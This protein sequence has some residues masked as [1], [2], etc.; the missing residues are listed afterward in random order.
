[1]LFLSPNNVFLSCAVD[2]NLFEMNISYGLEINLLCQQL[3]AQMIVT[4]IFIIPSTDENFP[5]YSI[6]HVTLYSAKLSF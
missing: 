6:Q 4:L 2:C 3:S 5:I 1:M